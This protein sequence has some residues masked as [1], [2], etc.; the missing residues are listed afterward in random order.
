[1]VAASKPLIA[2]ADDVLEIEHVFDAP[3]ELVFD[4]WRDPSHVVRWWGP[5]GYR[6]THCAMDFRVGGA[7]RFRQSGPR[8]NWI[9]GTY[10][11]IVPP[12]RLAFTYINERDGHEMLVTLDFEPQ[13]RQTRMRFRQAPFMNV[14]E[15]DGHNGG[16]TSTFGMLD[17]YIANLGSKP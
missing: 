16:W 5:R 14:R 8:E 9:S 6:L 12:S 4:L 10:R 11:E 15:R 7:W 13:G 1:V 3:R 2:T 17:E